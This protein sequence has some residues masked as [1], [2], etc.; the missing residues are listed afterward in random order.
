MEWSTE[1]MKVLKILAYRQVKRFS[2]AKNKEAIRRCVEEGLEVSG[3]ST[4]EIP[5]AVHRLIIRG[6]SHFTG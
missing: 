2:H 1:E 4:L 3:P 5:L 6:I